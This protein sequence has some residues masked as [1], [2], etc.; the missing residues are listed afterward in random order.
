M[1]PG[2]DGNGGVR[3][4]I[5]VSILIRPEGRMQR[6]VRRC[7]AAQRTASVSIL[8]RPEGRMQPDASRWMPIV[9]VFQSSSGQKAGCNPA[10]HRRRRRPHV[11]S[12]LIRPEGRMQPNF[13]DQSTSLSAPNGPPGVSILIRPEGRMQRLRPTKVSGVWFQWPAGC[14]RQVAHGAPVFQSS[15]GQKAGCNPGHWTGIDP[16]PARRPDEPRRADRHVRFNPHPARRPDATDGCLGRTRR[17]LDVFQSSSGQKAGCNPCNRHRVT[18]RCPLR[19]FNPHP[20][21]RPDATP[22]T[23][24]CGRTNGNWEFQSSSGQ[25]AGCNRRRGA[26]IWR[27]ATDGVSILIRPEGRMQLGR[28][29]RGTRRNRFNPHPAR[30]P[31]ATSA[32]PDLKGGH[33]HL[34]QSSSG[35]KA[36][37]NPSA[38]AD[39]PDRP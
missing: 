4:C 35:Q 23:R 2:A 3:S 13:G 33:F 20:A 37:C 22:Y 38:L 34:F 24:R 31:D 9:I 16:H 8:I 19:C 26:R 5:S 21:R 1:Q 17:P 32:L 6:P 39:G 14:N 12:I 7:L 18:I 15:S 11:V 28:L 10:M 27:A 29:V 30:R 36:G 25:K